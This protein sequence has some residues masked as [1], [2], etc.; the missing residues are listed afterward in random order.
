MSYRAKSETAN[1]MPYRWFRAVADGHADRLSRKTCLRSG[2][3][4][5][6][7]TPNTPLAPQGSFCA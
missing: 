4:E 2:R 1:D 6:S 3:G 5:G 7:A